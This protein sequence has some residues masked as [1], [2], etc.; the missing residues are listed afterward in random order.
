MTN[1]GK[2]IVAGVVFVMSV[3]VFMFVFDTVTINGHSIGVK[4]SWG[5]GVQENPLTPRT[6]F[7]MP[8]ERVYVYPAG[9]QV[10]EMSDKEKVDDSYLVQSSDSQDMHL[11]LQTQWHIDPLHVINLHKTVG[12]KGIE[13]RVLRPTLL[14]V[15]KN[16]ATI[17]KALD[18]YS[19]AGLVSLQKEIED[20]LNDEDGD[21]RRR[22][23]IVDNFVIEHIKL[24]SE[25]V[26]EITARQVAIQREMRAVQEEKAAQADALKAKAVA[27]SDLNKAVVE[28]ERDKQV[29]VLKAEALNETAVLAAEA[30]KQKTVLAA[31][32]EKE[33]GELKAAAILAIG[34]AKAKAATLEYT[35]YGSPGAETYAKIQIAESMSKAFGNIKGYLP[36]NMNVYTLGNSFTDAIEN[37][38]KPKGK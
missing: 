32:A 17:K 38:V 37:L 10:F 25:Y 22:G 29:A 15:V 13:E 26:K 11:S 23:I 16:K 34:E 24:D 28:A 20:E 36:E 8:W 14:T 6:Y 33:S 3:A 19:G 9:V 1:V 30:E 31:E 7:V 4:E 12:A 21:L 5:G 18:A 27:Q 2:L 35:A